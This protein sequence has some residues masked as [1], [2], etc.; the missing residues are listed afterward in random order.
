MWFRNRENVFSLI[1][2]TFVTNRAFR[3]QRNKNSLVCSAT[4]SCS[5]N[6]RSPPFPAKQKT[7]THHAAKKRH[8]VCWFVPQLRAEK[9]NLPQS[10]IYSC[11]NIN[12]THSRLLIRFRVHHPY[13]RFIFSFQFQYSRFSEF[14][15]PFL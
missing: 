15:K 5:S 13:L 14:V 12:Q 10:T 1:P 6:I 9:I 4:A 7:S 8:A 2:H 11:T 3:P